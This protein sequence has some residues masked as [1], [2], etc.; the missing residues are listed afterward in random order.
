MNDIVVK[1]DG[2]VVRTDEIAISDQKTRILANLGEIIKEKQEKLP[3]NSNGIPN[4]Y[5]DAQI[6]LDWLTTLKSG[7]A[8]ELPD[9]ILSSSLVPVDLVEGIPVV[10]GLPLWERFDCEPI[11]DYKLFKLYRDSTN[12]DGVNRRSFENLSD[13]TRIKVKALW[14]LSKVYHWQLRVRAYDLFKKDELEKEKA[15]M[16][17]LMETTHNTAADTIFEKCVDYFKGLKPE[18]LAKINPKDMLGWFVEVVRLKRLALG[19]PGDKP[20]TIEDRV[21]IDKLVNITQTENKTLNISG[22][23]STKYL[24]EMVDILS[25][26]GALPR[27]VQVKG[28]LQSELIKDET[29]EIEDEE[30]NKNKV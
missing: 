23:N 12:I 29:K 27:E 1:N 25:S 18:D 26:A 28:D 13:S 2:T 24:Q 30:N 17:K 9:K 11:D 6:I 15:K 20:A 5:I 22:E 16:I 8:N 14:A 3:K 19:L 21:K 10:N 4:Y 7:E